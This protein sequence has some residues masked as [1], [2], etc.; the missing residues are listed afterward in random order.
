MA[1]ATPR[2]LQSSITGHAYQRVSIPAASFE[3]SAVAQTSTAMAPFCSESSLPVGVS[4]A[5]IV[6]VY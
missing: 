4:H 6:A 3:D 1:S 5:G 2:R